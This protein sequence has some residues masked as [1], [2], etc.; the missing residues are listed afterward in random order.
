MCAHTSEHVLQLALGG[1]GG[2]M[3]CCSLCVCTCVYACMRVIACSEW[4]CVRM[5]GVA[6]DLHCVIVSAV[7][8]DV[9]VCVV[10]V[11]V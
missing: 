5:Y 10:C 3:R 6:F 2:C 4:R 9:C 1:G 7:H 8:V 11:C